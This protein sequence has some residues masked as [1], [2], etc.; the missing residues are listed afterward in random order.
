M[1]KAVSKIITTLY[2]DIVLGIFPVGN[3]LIEERLAAR[4]DVNRHTIREA[5][6]H[7]DELGFV[8]RVPNRGVFVREMPPTE[9]REIY[10]IR[11]LLECHAAAITRLPADKDLTRALKDI[12]DRH[13]KAIEDGD[14][15]A[16]LHSNTEFHRVQ[17]SA[18]S[19]A[20]LV[21]AIEDFAT[22]VHVITAMKYGI[23]PIMQQV[24]KHHTAIIEALEGN[25]TD[26]LVETVKQHFDLRQVDEYERRYRMKYGDSEPEV[27][28]APKR[29]IDP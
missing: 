1:S 27:S 6:V 14:Y 24:I 16:V 8:E 15:R 3:K 18:C 23:D 29:R 2:E 26:R 10:D 25:S 19:S 11:A 5:F 13:T 7:L 12:Q 20:T 4:F 9:V 17:F 22:R 28:N 21:A